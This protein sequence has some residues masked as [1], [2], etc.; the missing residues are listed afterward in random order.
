M[1][2]ESPTQA[3]LYNRMKLKDCSCRSSRVKQPVSDEPVPPSIPPIAHPHSLSEPCRPFRAS[4]LPLRF[5]LKIYL[6]ARGACVERGAC[7]RRPNAP[8]LNQSFTGEPKV[9]P[10]RGR[11]LGHLMISFDAHRQF[12]CYRSRRTPAITRKKFV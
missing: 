6:V 11:K 5:Q 2:W 12:R 8:I 4:T 10:T 9:H 1:F 7:V 3:C